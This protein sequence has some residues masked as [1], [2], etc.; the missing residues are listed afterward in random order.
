MSS[1]QS[2]SELETVSLKHTL[3]DARDKILE[4]L[5][6][7]LYMRLAGQYSPDITLPDCITAIDQFFYELDSY[8]SSVESNKESELK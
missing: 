8:H 6:N 2:S 1:N 7:S 3:L 5:E 4:V